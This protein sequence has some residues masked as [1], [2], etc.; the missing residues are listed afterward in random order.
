MKNL[1]IV[2]DGMDG[3]GKSTQISMLHDYLFKKN[4]RVRILTTREPTYGIHGA[5]IRKK[6]KQHKDPYKDSKDLLDLYV[7]DRRDH[8]NR[9]IKP[10][11]RKDGENVSIVLCDRYY[12]STIAYQHAQGIE[13]K[14]TLSLNK[15]FLK[16]DI[17]II[18]DLHPETALKRISKARAVEKFE[19][20][21]FMKKLRT[22]FLLLH[23]L[24]DDNMVII[25]TSGKEEE[26]FE[27]IC[28][29]VD[30]LLR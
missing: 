2:F 20:L 14:K 22:N 1:F 27:K 26:A 11:L 3:T 9:M 10:F 18:L 19:K 21:E 28:K 24:I 15:R 17:A 4:K 23:E 8:V 6:L 25:D 30:K 7:K 5:K 16:P 29:K 12:Y 13:L